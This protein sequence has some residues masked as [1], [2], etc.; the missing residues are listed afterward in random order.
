VILAILV[1]L[2]TPMT[3]GRVRSVDSE[4]GLNWTRL[5]SVPELFG[6]LAKSVDRRYCRYWVEEVRHHDW[7]PH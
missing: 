3:G 7:F 4:P 1:T 6:F 5:C 2:V